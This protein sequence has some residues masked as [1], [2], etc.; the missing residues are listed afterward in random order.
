MKLFATAWLVAAVLC[1]QSQQQRT[2]G[3][4]SVLYPGLGGPPPPSAHG[5]FGS[6]LF[7]GL[8]APPGTRVP[9]V[10]PGA[11][12]I[13]P[14]RVAHPLHSRT[15]I[16]P[17]PVYYGGYYYGADASGAPPPAPAYDA[18]AQDGSGQGPVVVL[19]Q[20][21]MPAPGMYAP[22]G[23]PPGAY[24][25]QAAPQDQPATIYLLALQDHSITPS[26][27]YWVEGDTLNYITTEGSENRISLSLI[28]RD[29]SKQLNESRHVD[30]KLPPAN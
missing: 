19:N 14:P 17:V 12:R 18:L 15:A 24:E 7:P 22:Q 11:T 9:V 4:G 29:F 13:A 3:F 2:T 25:A 26:I 21:Y 23:P 28:D 20:G 8:G 6:V 27:A 5:G 10:R 1:A 16:V 30:F